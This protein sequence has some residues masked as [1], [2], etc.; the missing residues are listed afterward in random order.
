MHLCNL[1]FVPFT[2]PCVLFPDVS[3]TEALVKKQ[4]NKNTF[5]VPL[6][7]C[8]STIRRHESSSKINFAEGS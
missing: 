7:L 2:Y 8:E 6:T 5:E 4:K 1:Y 3:Y